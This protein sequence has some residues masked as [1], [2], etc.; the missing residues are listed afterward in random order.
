MVKPT[1][2]SGARRAEHFKHAIVAAAADQRRV[3]ALSANL[4][5]EP[6]VVVERPTEARLE[7]DVGGRDAWR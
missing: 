2:G 5:N 4:E 6:G 7:T 1:A 3:D